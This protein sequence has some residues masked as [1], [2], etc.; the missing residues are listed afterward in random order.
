[1][2]IIWIYIIRWKQGS[3]KKKNNKENIDCNIRIC[4]CVYVEFSRFKF[5]SNLF[6][7]K[8]HILM[9][10][11]VWIVIFTH[12][13]Q[14]KK[15]I[16]KKL[17]ILLNRVFNSCVENIRKNCGYLWFFSMIIYGLLDSLWKNTES[18]FIYI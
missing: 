16:K 13:I 6:L 15:K 18:F 10:G 14:I 12:H 7:K 9:S 1:M 8:T 5:R 17:H 3:Q 4:I 2:C 11:F